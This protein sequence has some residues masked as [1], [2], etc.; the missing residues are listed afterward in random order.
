MSRSIKTYPATFKTFEEAE[1]FKLPP[2]TI[3]HGITERFHMRDGEVYKTTYRV[4]YR[5]V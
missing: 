1:D 2:N 3:L 5:H 4:K